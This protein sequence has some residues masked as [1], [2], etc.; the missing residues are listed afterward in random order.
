MHFLAKFIIYLK[1][2]IYY[3]HTFSSKNY[4]KKNTYKHHKIKIKMSKEK[5]K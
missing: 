2:I 3:F 4:F 1:I 5:K